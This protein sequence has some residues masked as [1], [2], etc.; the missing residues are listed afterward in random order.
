VVISGAGGLHEITVPIR[1]DLPEATGFVENNGVVSIEAPD[2]TN[3][4]DT[5]EISWTV[6]PNLGR[7]GSSVIVE[8][9]NAERQTPGDQAPHLEYEFTVFDSGDLTVE[10]YLSPTLNYKKN[11]GLKFA[12]AIDD[13]APQIIN[14]HEGEVVPD[15][16]YPEWWNNSVTDHI[17]IKRSIHHV[18]APGPHTLKVWMVDPGVVF[19]KFVIDAGG[20]QPSYLGP[21]E[22]VRV[23]GRGEM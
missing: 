17:K 4:Y 1:N 10:T 14:M 23:D 16:E 7:T 19:Q 18:S 13:E 12:L 6:V 22:S 15:W 20:L 5:S 3:A 21:P 2:F 9:S 11:E 8:P